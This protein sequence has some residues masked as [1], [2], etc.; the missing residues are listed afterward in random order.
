[1]PVRT[2]SSSDEVRVGRDVSLGHIALVVGWSFS[3]A[4]EPLD[5]SHPAWGRFYPLSEWFRELVVDLLD[6][7]STTVWE[8]IYHLAGIHVEGEYE[9]EEKA[10]EAF[11][12][13]ETTILEHP[14]ILDKMQELELLKMNH[15]VMSV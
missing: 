2:V 5:E 4:V 8:D 7:P 11:M 6:L 3:Y 9:S 10:N 15:I 14:D 13:G 1:M 12:Y